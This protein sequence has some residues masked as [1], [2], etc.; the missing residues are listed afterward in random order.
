MASQVYNL[1]LPICDKVE[2]KLVLVRLKNQVV[3]DENIS[4]MLPWSSITRAKRVVREQNFF[5]R[6]TKREYCES[7]APEKWVN[8]YCFAH[9]VSVKANTAVFI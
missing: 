6:N 9:T 4:I 2:I 1:P 3:G 7:Y 8:R 5:R